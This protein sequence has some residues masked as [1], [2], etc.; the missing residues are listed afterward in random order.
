MTAGQQLIDHDL[1]PRHFQADL[2]RLYRRIIVPALQEMPVDLLVAT[3]EPP[4]TTETYLE[5]ASERTSALLAAEIRRGFTLMLAALFERQLALW[6][7]T[8]SMPIA[9][10]P[11]FG[12]QLK[13]AADHGHIDLVAMKL[14]SCLTDLHTLA[15]VVRHGDGRSLDTLRNRSPDLWPPGADLTAEE[16]TIPD[17]A[18]RKFMLALSRFWGLADRFPMAVIDAPY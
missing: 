18:F 11:T 6:I 7:A 13:S 12:Q 9:P 3:P 16:L 1:L 17:I 2:D 5:A 14:E 15:N 4:M 8:H 10:K